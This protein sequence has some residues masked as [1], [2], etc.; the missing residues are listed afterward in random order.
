MRNGRQNDMVL[1]MAQIASEAEQ[2]A[3]TEGMTPVDQAAQMPA[4]AGSNP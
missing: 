1:N 2:I 3:G 4:P